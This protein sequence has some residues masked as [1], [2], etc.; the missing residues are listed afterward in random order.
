MT[1]MKKLLAAAPV[2]F[3]SLL[4]PG[5]FKDKF[6]HTYTILEPVYKSKTEVY[7][8][9][10]SNPPREIQSPGKIYVYGHYIFLNEINKG[11]HII[12]NTNPSHPVAK[13]FIDIPGNLDIG[14]KGNTLFADLYSD[15][16]TVDI[17]DP[18]N[19]K[20]IGY[21]S[22]VFPERSYGNGF[23]ADNTQVIVDWIQKDTTVPY[24]ASGVY[25]YP[26]PGVLYFNQAATAAPAPTGI[27]GSMARF[28][29]LNDYLYAVNSHTLQC[30]P[31][32]NPAQ[33]TISN[34]ISAGWDIETIYPFQNKLFLGSMGGVFIF[35]ISQPD[36]PIQE[37]TFVHAT[38]CDPVI[39]DDDYA[40]VT[41]REG[42]TCGPADNELLV[43]NIKDL[44]SP[45]LV[46]AYTMT[47]PQ[48][49]TKDNN[50]LF[51]CDGKDGL[52][53]YDVS[54]PANI[55]LKKHIQGSETYDAIAWNKNL[56]VVANDGLY[57]YN[58]SNP[59]DLV[60]ESKLTVNH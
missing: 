10:K 51:I 21:V 32:S 3:I 6:T 17:S 42:T 13:A 60:L 8:N 53:M 36:N 31:I 34:S 9:I 27:S 30:I 20:L 11:V 46:K 43:I 41:L 58:Y 18:L 56:I 19:A 28:I 50:R 14:V 16:V 2:I 12:D 47:N 55:V 40:Y 54:D 37:G 39:A 25:G 38:A 15:L 59:D 57:Q 49:L 35:D 45:S 33:L 26:V 48:G 24:Q 1:V 22:N 7:A 52:K 5:C 44:Q 29:I 23:V 4:L